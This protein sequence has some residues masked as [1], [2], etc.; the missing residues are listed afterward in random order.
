[1]AGLILPH[2]GVSP[3]IAEDVF[4]AETAVVIGDVE[5]GAGS[6]IWYGCV[7]RGDV[8]RIRVGRNTNLQDG[9]IVHCNNDRNGD[10]RETGGGEPTHIGDD[11]V[12]GHMVLNHA[13]TVGDGAF[14]GLRSV[15]PDRAVVEPRAMVAAGAVVTP[16]KPVPSGQLWVGL[17]PPYCRV[18]GESEIA[19]AT[20]FADHYRKL[21][22]NYLEAQAG[23]DDSA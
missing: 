2:R 4:I 3:K 16:G 8:N 22:A 23:P 13:C 10:Y 17:P 6:S 11:V 7:L 20:W 19:E 15:I 12:V 9:T 14:L 18:L 1:M 5:I 21:G